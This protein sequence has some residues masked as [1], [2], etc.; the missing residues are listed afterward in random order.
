MYIFNRENPQNSESPN[1]LRRGLDIIA[2]KFII[3]KEL[4]PF[5]DLHLIFEKSSLSF[6]TGVFKNQVQINR[7]RGKLN[8][9]SN[10]EF[11]SIVLLAQWNKVLEPHFASKKSHLNITFKIVNFQK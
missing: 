1:G 4:D 10:Y 2:L 11:F 5:I 6:Q 8:S 7:G 9:Y 3:H